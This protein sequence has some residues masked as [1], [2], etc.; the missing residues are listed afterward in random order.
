MGVIVEVASPLR[1]IVSKKSVGAVMR[2]MS[3][4]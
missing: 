1:K 3:Y 2:I 4:L